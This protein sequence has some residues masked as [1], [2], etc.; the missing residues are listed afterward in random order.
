MQNEANLKPFLT[1]SAIED[2]VAGLG[3][4]ISQDYQKHLGN[5]GELLVVVTLK[6]AL[7]FAADLIRHI[8][9]PVRIDFVRV[10]SY[11]SGTQ[12]S[13]SVL[14]TK[15]LETDPK[16]KHV[17]ILDEIVDTGH[18]IKFLREKFGESKPASLKVC[19]LLSKPSRREVEVPVE[20]VGRDVEDKFLVGYGLDYDEKFRNLKDIF[21]I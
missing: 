8:T 13:G 12:S 3:K 21:Y 20:Y 18:T 19:T 10:A 2:L 4:Q 1:A 6:G 15:D 5:S 11:G 9:V 14:M 16:G 7:L 17:L